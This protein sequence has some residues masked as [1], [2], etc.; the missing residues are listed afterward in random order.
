[1]L[2]SKLFKALRAGG[3]GHKAAALLADTA[4]KYTLAD[5]T[6]GGDSAM[7]ALSVGAQYVTKYGLLAAPFLQID[8]PPL[9]V[10]AGGTM[11]LDQYDFIGTDYRYGPGTFAMAF[12]KVAD[13]N[14][15]PVAQTQTLYTFTRDA[16]AVITLPSAQA[17]YTFSKRSDGEGDYGVQVVV[18]AAG[19]YS[20]APAFAR[21]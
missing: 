20:F 8:S 1:M 2:D 13:A 15:I 19:W 3:L 7:L 12:T 21:S 10:V 17:G 11:H 6:S 14:G 18:A 9:P 16:N 5:P 4:S